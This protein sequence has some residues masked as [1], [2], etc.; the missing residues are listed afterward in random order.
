MIAIFLIGQLFSFGV[1]VS[2][3]KWDADEHIEDILGEN[4]A[5][6]VRWLGSE[7]MAWNV[8][9]DESGLK[10]TVYDVVGIMEEEIE[11][12]YFDED[13]EPAD[14]V[15]GNAKKLCKAFMYSSNF[16]RRIS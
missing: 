16:A 7:G 15:G 8:F 13:E 9:L 3:E 12:S 6:V 11:E 1:Y 2:I 14:P 5:N 4:V 10:D